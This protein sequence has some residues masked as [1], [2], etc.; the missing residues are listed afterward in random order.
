METSKIEIKVTATPSLNKVKK[1][2]ARHGWMKK[3]LK[4][5][6]GYEFVL[7]K[8]N[9]FRFIDIIRY[10]SKEFDNDNFVGGCKNLVDAIKK[11][12]FIVDDSSKWVKINYQ[13]IRCRRGEEKTV[14]FI[15]E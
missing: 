12:G 4:E 6:A 2:Q 9:G 15:W 3:Y 10:G 11:K 8:A 5:L 13:Q 14:V 1:W 7:K